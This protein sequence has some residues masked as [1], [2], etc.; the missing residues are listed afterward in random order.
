MYINIGSI[1]SFSHCTYFKN[2]KAMI[3]LILLSMR[4]SVFQ[5]NVKKALVKQGYTDYLLKVVSSLKDEKNDELAKQR[6]QSSAD[7]IVMLL[8][9]GGLSFLS[10]TLL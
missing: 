8:T 4:L 10:K 1:T 9:E 5:D 7:I 2:F 3:N 6:V